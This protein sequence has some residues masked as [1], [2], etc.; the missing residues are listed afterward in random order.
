MIL[1]A[2]G[3]SPSRPSL[4]ACKD[5]EWVIQPDLPGH[6]ASVECAIGSLDAMARALVECCLS[7]E[8]ESELY[9]EAHQGAAG[10]AIAVA[11][12]WPA[13]VCGLTLIQ[14]WLLEEEERD[15]L[16]RHLP[17][18]TP[19]PAGGHLLEAWQWERER[20]FFAPWQPPLAAHRIPGAAPE[21]GHVHANTVALIGLGDR[22]QALMSEL[23]QVKL[24]EKLLSMPFPIMLCFDPARDDGRLAALERQIGSIQKQENAYDE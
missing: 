16:L 12:H 21:V 15:W 10:L 13:S 23:I 17:N 2:P 8:F 11:Q 9:I 1:H 14:P 7:L 5:T 18:L 22:L 20:H 24:A 4:G 6:G 3:Q 19:L